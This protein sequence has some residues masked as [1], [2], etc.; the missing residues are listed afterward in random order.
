MKHNET[1]SFEEILAIAL[2]KLNTEKNNISFYSWP[3]IFPNTAGPRNAP[4]IISGQACTEFQ[5]YAFVDNMTDKRIKYCGSVW[6][7]WNGDINGRW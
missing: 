3:A 4:G 6:K 7:E 2:D 1:L 5:V